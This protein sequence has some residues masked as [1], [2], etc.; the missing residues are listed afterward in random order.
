[1]AKFENMLKVDPDYYSAGTYE[2]EDRRP[3]I[4][5]K[6]L[7]QVTTILVLFVA[8]FFTYKFM[9]KRDL[10]SFNFL[11]SSEIKQKPIEQRVI[12]KKESVFSVTREEEIKRVTQAVI[13]QLKEKQNLVVTPS[14]VT[15][16]RNESKSKVD[17][18]DRLTQEYIELV[19]K[20]LGNN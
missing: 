1:M 15:S 18:S 14:I 6:V 9:E 5:V 13:S 3:P 20:S 11:E 17:S 7:V 12:D 10:F 19:K 16:K 2:E 8:L 4:F